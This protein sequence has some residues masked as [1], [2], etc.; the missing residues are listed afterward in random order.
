MTHKRVLLRV[1]DIRKKK[2]SVYVVAFISC[3]LGPPA[4]RAN[5][6]LYNNVTKWS[7]A[8]TRQ[9]SDVIIRYCRCGSINALS[10]RD[11]LMANRGEPGTSDN[12]NIRILPGV[13]FRQTCSPHRT[14]ITRNC[15]YLVTALIDRVG[16]HEIK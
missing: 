9:L 4:T 6:R 15:F 5:N 13:D 1:Y 2:E 8:N 3:T 16:I 12:D 7:A 10:L 11:R 14:P